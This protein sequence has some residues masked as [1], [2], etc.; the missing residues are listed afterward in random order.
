MADQLDTVLDDAYEALYAGDLDKARAGLDAARR[1]APEDRDVLLLEVDLLD[2]DG[3]GEEALAA[4]EQDEKRLKGDLALGFRYATLLLDFYDD[5]A[6]ARPFLENVHARI[7]KGDTPFGRPAESDDE[8]EELTSFHLEVLLTLSDTRASTYDPAGALEAADA[9]VKLDE[10]EPSAQVA[11]GAAL[12]DLC[13]LDDAIAAA[14]AALEREPRHP[15]A[16]WLRGRIRTVRGEYDEARRDFEKAAQADPD[17]FNLPIEITEDDFV[18]HMERALE[19]LPER[20][21]TYLKN[22]SVAVEDIPD[23]ARLKEGDPPLSPGLLGLYEGTPPSL[24]STEDPWSHFPNHVTLFRKNIEI[25]ARS[26]DELVDL[27]GTTLLHEVGHY[28]GLDEDDLDE[29]G[30]G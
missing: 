23:L 3:L 5:A 17:R 27:I 30:L 1:A 24:S 25:A 22:V 4:L 6:S 26:D 14:D 11:R 13:R 10:D 19:E 9:A 20:V 29:R 15:D 8:R 12:F 18:E 7:Q 16:C 2:A 21:Q 28:L